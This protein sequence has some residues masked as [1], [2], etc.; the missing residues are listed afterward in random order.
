M[1]YMYMHFHII[2]LIVMLDQSSPSNMQIA[3]GKIRWQTLVMFFLHPQI[4]GN[5]EKLGMTLLSGWHPAAK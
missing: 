1:P 3:I 4:Y 5:L 2:Q